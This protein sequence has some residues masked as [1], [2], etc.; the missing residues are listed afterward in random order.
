ME[1]GEV[2]SVVWKDKAN[3]LVMFHFH[4]F[5]QFKPQ[6]QLQKCQFTVIMMSV[7]SM[8][9]A[10]FKE[11]IEAS[12]SAAIQKDGQHFSDMHH[13]DGFLFDF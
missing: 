3:H 6:S 9:M 7:M 8:L 5:L 1:F 10:Q 12:H 2:H 13:D 11:Q 4:N